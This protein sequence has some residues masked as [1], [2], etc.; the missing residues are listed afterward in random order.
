MRR[1]RRSA[2]RSRGARSRPRASEPGVRRL[3]PPADRRAL[4]RSR[5][6][7]SRRTCGRPPSPRPVGAG[8]G[9]SSVGYVS[10]G[11]AS[12][13]L[14]LGGTPYAGAHGAA[15]LLGSAELPADCPHCSRSFRSASLEHVASGPA[16]VARSATRRAEARSRPARSCW[17]SRGRATSRREHRAPWCR[18]ARRLRGAVRTS[19]TRRSS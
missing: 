3:D 17:R 12:R 6:S 5:R 4:G 1:R 7:R 8:R 18:D 10:V 11:T 9:R 19:S 16:L 13:L 14:V 15:Q 2:S